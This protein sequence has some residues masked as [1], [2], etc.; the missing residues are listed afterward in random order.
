MNFIYQLRSDVLFSVEY[1]Y[2]K[3]YELDDGA[4]SA[5]HINVSLGYIF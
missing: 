3:T 1:R 5:H 2:L 4:Y